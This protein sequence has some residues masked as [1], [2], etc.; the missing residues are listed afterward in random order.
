M[1]A[2]GGL[3]AAEATGVTN[4]SGGARSGGGGAAGGGG[5]INVELPEVANGI[6]GLSARMDA[7]TDAVNQ[8]TKL[9]AQANAIA[10]D[11][12]AAANSGGKTVETIRE[13]VIEYVP[14]G[15]GGDGGGDPPIDFGGGTPSLLEMT[16]PNLA[17]LDVS[18]NGGGGGGGG[19]SGGPSWDNHPDSPGGTKHTLDESEFGVVRDANAA[20][21]G[22]GDV[23]SGG[24]DLVNQARKTASTDVKALTGQDF[25]TDG[26]FYD[27]NGK[28][29]NPTQNHFE[30][31]IWKGPDPFNLG[32]KKDGS[33]SSSSRPT[34]TTNKDNQP[35][36]TNKSQQRKQQRK[37]KGKTNGSTPFDKPLV[38]TGS[39]NWSL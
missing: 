34:V 8:A 36:S 7:T 1:Y 13:T 38:P 10:A 31:P 33:Q 4:F 5:P 30:G 9:A 32:G 28:Q 11:A 29:S 21:R 37:D 17:G 12:Q 2:V 3:I 26:T 25:N 6:A 15:G 24:A 19:P 18:G 22:F 39:G 14:T 23:I 27:F 16:N 20:A 35:D